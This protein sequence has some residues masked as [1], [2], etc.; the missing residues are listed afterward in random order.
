MSSLFLKVK[1]RVGLLGR[2]DFVGTP[3]SAEK[4]KNLGLKI[5]RVAR[6]ISRLILCGDRFLFL[7]TVSVQERCPGNFILISC[8]IEGGELSIAKAFAHSCLTVSWGRG[9]LG[10]P[11]MDGRK[12]HTGGRVSILWYPY[13]VCLKLEREIYSI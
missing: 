9:L 1:C 2:G 13:H 12:G 6:I 8:L 10:S 7:L 4:Y 5:Q 11:L 3:K